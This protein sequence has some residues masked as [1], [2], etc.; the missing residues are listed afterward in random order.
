MDTSDTFPTTFSMLPLLMGWSLGGQFVLSGSGSYKA[1]TLTFTLLPTG[2]LTAAGI[3][4]FWLARRRV[5]ADGLAAPF[6]ATL[7]R[8]GAEALA[9]ALLACYY[10]IGRA[11]C[12]ERV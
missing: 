3:G 9:V 1:I 2:A 4:V 5:A 6:V 12:R 7:A 8:A 10:E 11:S